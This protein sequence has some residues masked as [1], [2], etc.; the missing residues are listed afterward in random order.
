MLANPEIN[1][2]TAY[3]SSW[4]SSPSP[5]P[6]A[7]STASAACEAAFLTADAAPSAAPAPDSVAAGAAFGKS[8]A[9]AASSAGT[10]T[11]TAWLPFSAMNL[12]RSSTVRAPLYAIGESFFPAAYSLMVGKPWISSGTSLAVASTLAMVTLSEW[13][14]KSSPS[15]SYLGARLVTN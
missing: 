1:N 11:L 10:S 7:A 15:S 8:D 13:P 3:N 4:I 5:P 12:T 9:A 14:L 6:T 2:Q